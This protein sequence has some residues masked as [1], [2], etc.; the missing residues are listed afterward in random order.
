[1]RADDPNLPILLHVAEALGDLR[2][3]LVFVGG[4]AAGLLLTDPVVSG[5]RATEDVDAIVEAASFT[6]FHAVEARLAERGFVRDAD[7]GV[8][9]RWKHR[10]SGTIFDLMP[11]EP[12]VLGFANRWYPE[13]VRSAI[14]VALSPV[15]RIHLISAPAFVA[16]KLEAFATRGNADVFSPD[17]EDIL[18]VVDGRP[19]LVQELKQAGD[20]MQR[21]LRGQVAA[22]LRRADFDNAL[23]GLI[24]DAT[25]AD[26]VLDRLRAM[27]T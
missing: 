25:R 15:L 17:L 4:C 13:A 7:S 16:T 12:G 11:S 19:E 22:L 21:A 14:E 23:P 6:R 24:T 2:D 9:C 5:V 8:I 3:E 10:A 1:M 26:I 18:V 27:A 20:E